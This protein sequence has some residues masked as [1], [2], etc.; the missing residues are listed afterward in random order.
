MGSVASVYTT[1]FHF[2]G[3]CMPQIALK[4]GLTG[5]YLTQSDIQEIRYTVYQ[6][7]ETYPRTLVAVDGHSNVSV[8]IAESVYNVPVERPDDSGEMKNVN[9]E[10]RLPTSEKPLFP[11]YGAI[12]RIQF[13]FILTD[14]NKTV[15]VIEGKAI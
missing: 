10:Y 14:G 3:P 9:F 5:N 1:K 13:D 11:T 2:N 6:Y 8:P 12:Y 4:S 15:A 7:I